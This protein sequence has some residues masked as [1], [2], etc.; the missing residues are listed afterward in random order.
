[1][2]GEGRPPYFGRGRLALIAAPH[3]ASSLKDSAMTFSKTSARV[4]YQRVWREANRERLLAAK[5]QYHSENREAELARMKARYEQNK[6]EYVARARA[7]A[8]ANPE[9]EKARLQAR[10]N[11]NV[12]AERQLR[13]EHY[14][15]HKST[16]VA[17]AK[18]RKVQLRDRIPAWADLGAVFAVYAEAEKMRALGLDVHVDHIIPLNGKTV[19]GLHVQNNLRVIL[20]SDNLAK[21]NK[22]VEV[23]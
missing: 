14:Q 11:T 10:Y 1:M 15:K 18:H 6:E 23:A 4:E 21:G 22:L 17:R 9:A 13:R 12:D 20:A 16:Y 2:P 19:S 7:R 8:L 3:L 5:R